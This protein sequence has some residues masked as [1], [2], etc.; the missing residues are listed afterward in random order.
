MK[1]LADILTEE[2][3]HNTSKNTLED[4]DSTDDLGDRIKEVIGATLEELKDS[5]SGS[6][7]K[8]SLVLSIL[9]I[10]SILLKNSSRGLT[11]LKKITKAAAERAMNLWPGQKQQ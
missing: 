6:E 4:L 8:K 5:L 3:E 2:E 11:K 9:K 7:K 10:I 1:E